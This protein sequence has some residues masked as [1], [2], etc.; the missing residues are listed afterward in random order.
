[1]ANTLLPPAERDLTPEQVEVLDK[2]RRAGHVCLVIAFQFIIVATLLTVWAGQ[3][4]T[5]APGW[6]HPMAYLMFLTGGLAVIF[7][8]VGITLRR[9]MP[10]FN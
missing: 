3:D 4:L 2:R 9:G 1:M 8:L 5:Y 7:A 10:E 6:A